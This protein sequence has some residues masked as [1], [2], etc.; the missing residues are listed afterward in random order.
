[1]TSHENDVRVFTDE[2]LKR[3][4]EDI[5]LANRQPCPM[6]HIDTDTQLALLHRLECSERVCKDMERYHDRNSPSIN[7]YDH[8]E[9]WRK[10]SGKDS[11]QG[12]AGKQAK[13]SSNSEE[14]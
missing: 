1:M 3:L 5:E 10:A 6:I 4:K 12:S 2:D 13:A 14:E 8:L 9:A 7:Y 11:P